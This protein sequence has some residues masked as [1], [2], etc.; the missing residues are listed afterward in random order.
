MAIPLSQTFSYW[1]TFNMKKIQLYF[2]F[3]LTT[4]KKC[5]YYSIITVNYYSTIPKINTTSDLRVEGLYE[6]LKGYFAQK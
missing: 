1:S 3:Q 5:H 6:T 2:G 4:E